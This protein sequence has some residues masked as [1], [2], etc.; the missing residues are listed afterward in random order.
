VIN[1]VVRNHDTT[2]D[3]VED[4]YTAEPTHAPT[5]YGKPNSMSTSFDEN[6]TNPHHHNITALGKRSSR[7]SL[8]DAIATPT[9]FLRKATSSL[10]SEHNTPRNSGTPPA[11]RRS[12]LRTQRLLI[13]E[14]LAEA[15]PDLVDPSY[16]AKRT[17]LLA[18]QAG[19]PRIQHRLR[20][21]FNV[22]TSP[23]A[24]PQAE[25]V[26]DLRDLSFETVDDD[27]GGMDWN[28]SKQL[29][30]ALRADALSGRRLVLP[31]LLC[32]ESQDD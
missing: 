32:A 31:P 4:L 29:A 28:R 21:K 1:N 20:L 17:R 13:A 25:A 14:R 19:S 8:P 6:A 3:P 2:P 12:Q 23:C 22:K 26:K 5:K 18:R 15:R 30:D 9:K 16:F 10:K 7:D 27:D 24:P 11:S